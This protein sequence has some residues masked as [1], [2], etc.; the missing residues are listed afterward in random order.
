MDH[1]RLWAPWRISYIAGD[2][3]PA[4]GIEPTSWQEGADRDCFLCRAAA[5]YADE[6][7]ARQQNLVVHTG[8]RVVAVL[9]KYPYNNGHLLVAP[10]RHVGQLAE[11]T[12]EEHLEAMHTLARFTDVYAKLMKAEAFNIGLNLG[13]PAGAGVPGHLHWHL[14]PRWTGDSNFMP[15][16]ADARVI[17]QSLEELWQALNQA[18][19]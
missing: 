2:K 18:T 8:A 4:P 12:D 13:K 15:V 19:I 14:V 6:T 7:A 10:W 11:L 5:S 1:E 9:N 3:T 17:S 16:V